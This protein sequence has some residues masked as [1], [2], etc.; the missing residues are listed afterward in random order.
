M[1]DDEGR[2]ELKGCDEDVIRIRVESGK[3]DIL[4]FELIR[5]QECQ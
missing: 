2:C 1:A 5:R 4:S 3:T